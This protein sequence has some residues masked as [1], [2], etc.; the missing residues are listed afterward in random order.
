MAV[1]VGEEADTET[2]LLRQ[3]LEKFQVKEKEDTLANLVTY[4]SVLVDREWRNTDGFFADIFK[5]PA[6]LF[7]ALVTELISCGSK[8][9]IDECNQPAVH[10]KE[11][12]KVSPSPSV[13]TI[14][15]ALLASLPVSTPLPLR[16]PAREW[17]ELRHPPHHCPGGS[18]QSRAYPE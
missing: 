10:V 1:E 12:K 4:Q 9:T 5:H 11:R 14:C 6:G 17:Y 3:W 2:V 16:C 18:L 8:D 7:D 13:G 15:P